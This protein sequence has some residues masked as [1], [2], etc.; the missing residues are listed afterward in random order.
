MKELSAL[1]QK[2]HQNIGHWKKI[3]TEVQYAAYISFSLGVWGLYSDARASHG[4][5][6]SSQLE[7]KEKEG[8]EE[9]DCQAVVQTVTTQLSRNS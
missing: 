6:P 4:C 7:K 9:R 8:K 3:K 2:K 5:E 1:L